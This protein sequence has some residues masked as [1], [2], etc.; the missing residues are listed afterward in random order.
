[1]L[2]LLGKYFSEFW[3]PLRLLNSH[4]ILL[5][6][7]VILS[8]L[9]TFI[10]LPKMLNVLPTDRGK[11]KAQQGAASKGKPTGAGFVVSILIAPILILCVPP[12][13]SLYGCIVCMYMVM[14]FGYLDDSAEIPWGE[15][16][17]AILDVGASVGA[18]WFLCQG[19]SMK[20][21]LPF[22]TDV[23]TVSPFVYIPMSTLI[24]FVAINSVNCNDGVD[25]LAGSLSLIT[26]ISL[27]AFLYGVV[28][29]T[30][31]AKYLLVPHYVA[32]AKWAILFIV[33]IG[34]LVGYLWFN[35]EPSSVLM[36]DAGSRML[37][38]AIG[39]GVL[40]SGNPFLIFVV[41][42]MILFNGLTGLIKLSL[43][44]FAKRLGWETRRPCDIPAESDKKPNLIIRLLHSVTFPLHD[45]CRKKLMWKNSQ[46][47]MRFVLIQSI[48]VP[49]LFVVLIKI[50]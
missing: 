11:L 25:G 1:M 17:K 43:L 18:A 24:L 28:G 21:W 48:L 3:G 35:A 41:A 6:I 37:G 16:K 45:H 26:L 10:F 33:M 44:R 32:S 12:D 2:Y 9:L 23:V 20:L 46:V 38:M 27:A 31:V 22:V 4:I 42:P 19:G 15:T 5:S 40:A 8:S 39:L 30:P 49:F 29:Y 50:R 14:L 47:L 7:G 36:G 13:A 34:A